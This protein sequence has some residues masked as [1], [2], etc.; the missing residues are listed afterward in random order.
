MKKLI[1]GLL[2]LLS[3]ASYAQRISDLPAA[4]T[5]G[6]TEVVAGVQ[7]STTKK[8]SINQ[9]RAFVISDFWKVTGTTT[10]TANTTID[11]GNF[12]LDFTNLATLDI[13]SN[14]YLNF[15]AGSFFEVNAA[16]DVIFTPAGDIYHNPGGFAQIHAGAEVDVESLTDV[17]ITATD[18]INLTAPI[19]KLGGQVG[20]TGQVPTINASGKLKYATPGGGGHVIEDEGTP[21]TQRTKLNFVGAGVTVTDDSGDD[22]SV[23]TIAGGGGS[24]GG[25]DTNV[26]YN[27]GGAFGGETGFTYAEGTNTLTIDNV[28]AGSASALTDGGSITITG[29]KHTLTSTQATITWT[30]SQT[31][32][33]QTTDII[34]NATATTWTFPAGALCVVDGIPSGTNIAT[35][36]G[37]S[38]DHHI[39]SIYKNG[40]DYRVVVKNFGQ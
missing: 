27:D 26:Q 30:L 11:G 23:V 38:G 31:G 5:L 29:T 35:L 28:T 19:I 40:T 15:N 1:I 4:T 10:L 34:L 16:T 36:A 6:G 9:I 21:L 12:A 14:T 18:S 7:S 13:A 22:A 32:D 37:V 20:T 17:S 39:L 24:P 2:T 3:F 33:Y 25:A 8:I